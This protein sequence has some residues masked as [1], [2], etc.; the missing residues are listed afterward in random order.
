M[1]VPLTQVLYPDKHLLPLLYE[2][3]WTRPCFGGISAI[4]DCILCGTVE[5]AVL[6]P[7]PVQTRYELLELC[8]RFRARLPK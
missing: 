2:A 3:R 5:Q 8:R 4:G 1:A 6:S 7:A